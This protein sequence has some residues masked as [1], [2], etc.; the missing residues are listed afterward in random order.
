MKQ[1][2]LKSNTS[3]LINKILILIL[4]IIAFCSIVYFLVL[5][6][7]KLVTLEKLISNQ[8]DIEYKIIDTY[9]GRSAYHLNINYNNQ[10]Y[11]VTL[12][13]DEYYYLETVKPK[14]YYYA[15]TN[16]VY[17]KLHIDLIYQRLNFYP[18]IAI[19]IALPYKLT[20]LLLMK[21]K[22]IHNY[23][24]ETEPK[25][26]GLYLETINKKKQKI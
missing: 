23:I 8:Y 5:E 9:Y 19:L 13:G 24:K 16:N 6:N 17:S 25:L 4:R 14:L 12:N 3:K 26:Y 11:D 2:K 10:N 15:K 20:A 18:F 22:P 1:T 21:I 7:E